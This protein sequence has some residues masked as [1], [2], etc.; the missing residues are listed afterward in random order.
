MSKKIIVKLNKNDVDSIT[1]HFEYRLG[2]K[3]KKNL[4]AKFIAYY[5]GKL[6]DNADSS[7]TEE[8]IDNFI[9]DETGENWS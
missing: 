9:Q 8:Y 7:E 6:I 5:W 3:A 4:V 2:K 1:S